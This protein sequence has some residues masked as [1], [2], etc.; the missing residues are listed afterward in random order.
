MLSPIKEAVSSTGMSSLSSF[1]GKKRGEDFSAEECILVLCFH[2]FCHSP[3][4][5]TSEI[6]SWYCGFNNDG[7]GA[8]AGGGADENN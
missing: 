1:L 7:G 6:G 4:W 2:L 3:R 8:G 5:L